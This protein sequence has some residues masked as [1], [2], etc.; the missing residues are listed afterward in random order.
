MALTQELIDLVTEHVGRISTD[1]LSGW[2]AGLLGQ[3]RVAGKL[4]DRRPPEHLTGSRYADWLAGYE[5]ASRYRASRRR[6]T[7][8]SAKGRYG[9]VLVVR[10]GWVPRGKT[11]SKMEQEGAYGDVAVFYMEDG[12]IKRTVNC[13]I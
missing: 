2:E 5:A 9:D 6:E 11:L 12:K 8:F 10:K 4:F 7:H 3:K 13:G 1:V